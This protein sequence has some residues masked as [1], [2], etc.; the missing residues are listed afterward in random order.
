[1]NWAWGCF[2]FRDFIQLKRKTSK[3]VI[4]LI[5]FQRDF[6]RLIFIYWE[7]NFDVHSALAEFRIGEKNWEQKFN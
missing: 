5:N 6:A 3:T 2:A 7:K 4:L 1:M